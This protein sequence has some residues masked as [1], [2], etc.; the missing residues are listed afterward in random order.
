MLSG[1]SFRL[2]FIFSIDSSIL[3]RFPSHL[4][5]ASQSAFLWLYTLECAVQLSENNTK[6]VLFI[7][8]H[9]LSTHFAINLFYLHNMRTNMLTNYG[10]TTESCMWT[11]EIK[12][13]P[14]P[15]HA[16][17]KLTTGSIVWFSLETIQWYL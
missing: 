6:F 1:P 12:T 5:E 11:N 9:I 10:T 17:F 13:K 15:S 2:V 7:I 3:Y 4:A 14:K 16:T 8:I